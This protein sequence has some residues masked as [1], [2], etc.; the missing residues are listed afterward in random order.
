MQIPKIF[1]DFDKV[2]FNYYIEQAGIQLNQE[3]IDLISQYLE[4]GFSLEKA[5]QTAAGIIKN[6]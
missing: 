5:V 4:M 3:A 6:K 1:H 2:T